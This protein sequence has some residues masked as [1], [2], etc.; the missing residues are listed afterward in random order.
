MEAGLGQVGGN[1]ALYLKLLKQLSAQLAHTYEP[2][3]AALYDC[4]N[5]ATEVRT[6]QW[7]PAMHT[8]KGTAGNLVLSALYQQAQHLDACLKQ[9]QC[10]SQAAV[11]A[12]AQTLQK[13]Q[14]AIE[15]TLAPSES[16]DG[17][18][19]GTRMSDE[20]LADLRQLQQQVQASEFVEETTLDAI[21]PEVPQAAMDDW[22]AV[23]A[24]LAS[25]DFDTAHVA[26]A[27]LLARVKGDG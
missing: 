19:S 5:T 26:L 2:M 11:A 12:Y 20:G 16:E 24:A 10:P 1:R 8:L 7:Q 27:R 17:P 15:T 9:G 6:E 25:F 23:M 14:Q 13:T 21:S 22:Q 18:P 4:E 3:V